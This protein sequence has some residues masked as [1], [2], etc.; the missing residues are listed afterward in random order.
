MKPIENVRDI[1]AL[2][3]GFI[4]SKAL[5][6]AVEF[7]LFTKIA[8]GADTLSEIAQASGIATNRVRTLLTALKTVGLIVEKNG[9]FSNAP[10]TATYL[11]AG[12]AGDFRDYIRVVNGGVMYESLRYLDPALRGQ[13]IFP[14]KGFY[15]G[16][17]Y[18]EGVGGPAFSAAQHAGSLGPARLLAKR[19]DLGWARTLLDVGGGSG[20]YTLALLKQNPQLRATILD[21]PETVATAKAYALQAGMNDRIRYLGGNALRTEWPENQ[22]VVLMSYLW[23]A[24]GGNDIKVLARRAYECLRPSGLVLV[25][26]FMVDDAHEAPSFAALYLLSAVLD[27]PEAECLTPALVEG[28]L[29]DAGLEVEVTEI[30]LEEITSVTRARRRR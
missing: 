7:D 18:S 9:R 14:D 24:V 11:V 1:S 23:S 5:F 10:T 26:D 22:D 8:S 13:R 21:F 4:A 25:H 3:Y 19:I 28:A 27:N 20:A 6:A 2:T 30:M 29:R 12:G 17:L 15:E 16:I